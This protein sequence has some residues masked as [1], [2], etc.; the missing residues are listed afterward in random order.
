MI[1][2][3]NRVSMRISIMIIITATIN[4]YKKEMSL[5]TTKNTCTLNKNNNNSIIKTI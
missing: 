2:M 4:C 5:T 1:L 3:T